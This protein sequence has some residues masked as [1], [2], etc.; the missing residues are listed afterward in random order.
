MAIFTPGPSI[1]EIRGSAGGTTYSR[2]RFGQ[3]TRQRS[4]PVNPNS[5]AQVAQRG[6]LSTATTYWRDT[7]TQAQRDAWDAYATNT[8]WTNALGLEITLT[9]LNHFL[10]TNQAA[11]TVGASVITAAPATTGI[12]DEPVLWT[13]TADA[14]GNTIDIAYT[15]PADVDDQFW[16]FYASRPFAAS[17]NFFGGPWRYIGNISGDSGSPPASPASFAYPWTLVAGQRVWVRARRLDADGRLT[18]PFRQTVLA[19]AS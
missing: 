3:Y 6:R 5:P 17:R 13:P 4:V 12:P 8:A 10:R 11:L 14:T 1:S 19:T 16:L 15:F 9:G 7:L 2:N 18:E